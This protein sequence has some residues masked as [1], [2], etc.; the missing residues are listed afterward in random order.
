MAW[1]NV[2]RNGD[3]NDRHVHT[4]ADWAVVYYPEVG[5]AEPGHDRNGRPELRD[6]RILGQASNLRGYGFAA[7]R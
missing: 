2:N 7:A 1:A 5:H 6:P 3:Y 4:G